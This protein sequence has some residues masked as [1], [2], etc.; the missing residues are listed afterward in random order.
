MIDTTQWATE[1]FAALNLTWSTLAPVAKYPKDAH[2]M[3]MTAD[4]AAGVD[5]VLT[6]K[7][8]RSATIITPINAAYTPLLTYVVAAIAGVDLTQADM[9]VAN[10]LRQLNKQRVKETQSTLGKIKGVASVTTVGVFTLTLVH[11]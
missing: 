6:D 1:T 8:I 7:A 11:R 3:G 10:M 4:R 9:W 5:L 2:I